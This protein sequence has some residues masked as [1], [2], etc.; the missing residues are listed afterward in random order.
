LRNITKRA[1]AELQAVAPTDWNSTEPFD[2]EAPD[3]VDRESPEPKLILAL[4]R[5]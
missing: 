2:P 4:D 1:I 5:L 3:E